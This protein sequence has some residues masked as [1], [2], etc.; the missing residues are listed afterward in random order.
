VAIDLSN[1]RF[2]VFGLPGSGKTELVKSILKSTSRH[3]VYDPMSEYT[4]FRRY[5]PDDRHS[6]QELNTVIHTLVI[7][8]KPK[9]FVIDEAN[10]YI[11]PKPSPLPSGVADL[12]DLSRHWGVS[13]GVVARRPVQFHT[14]VVELCH[15]LFVFGLHGRNDRRWGNDIKEGL[16]D[17][18]DELPPHHFVVV[19]EGRKWYIHKPITIQQEVTNNGQRGSPD[20]GK[21]Q[22][23]LK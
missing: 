5:V 7:P 16:G 14:D 13:W 3:L 12:N 2:A 10:S 23:S 8:S 20:S 1:K 21:R 6:V 19:E 4:G 11:Q 18:L 15:Y 22:V 9:L 17:T